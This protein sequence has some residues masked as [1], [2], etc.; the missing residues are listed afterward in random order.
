VTAKHSSA[1]GFRRFDRALCLH[2]ETLETSSYTPSCSPR[3]A[4]NSKIRQFSMC[5]N[6]AFGDMLLVLASAIRRS[7]PSI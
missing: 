6:E 1:R 7:S 4:Q 3:V 5:V 2:R